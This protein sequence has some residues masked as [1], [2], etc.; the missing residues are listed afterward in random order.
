RKKSEDV[1]LP[2]GNQGAL[3]AFEAV[4]LRAVDVRIYR[5]YENNIIQF[6]QVN[7]LTGD[8]QLN[9]VGKPIF[10]KT[11][12]L[13]QYANTDLGQWNT[14]YIDLSKI[15][16]QQPG[17]LYHIKI[18]FRQENAITQC[19]D[20]AGSNKAVIAPNDF[21][22]MFTNYYYSYDY[23]WRDRDNPC[24]EAYYGYRRAMSHNFMV[25]DIGIIA[26]QGQGKEL[27]V[28]TT[29][30]SNTS[31]LPGTTVEVLDYQ[32]QVLA[33]QKTD[34]D[35]K[36]V[37]T[38][39]DKPY[40][41]KASDGNHTSYLRLTSSESLSYSHF[42]TDGVT[43]Q[44]GIKGFIY[45]ERGVY[46][47]GDTI[48]TGFMLNDI[49]GD[50]PENAPVT[51]EL[52]NARG[53]QIGKHVIPRN[54]ADHYLVHFNTQDDDETGLWNIKAM[55]GNITF[56]QSVS[57]ETVKPNRLKIDIDID[58]TVYAGEDQKIN[59]HS[60]WLHG[61]PVS[62]LKYTVEGAAQ[63]SYLKFDKYPGFEFNHKENQLRT[64]PSLY[65]SGSLDASGNAQIPPYSPQSS[66]LPSKV[67]L[68]YFFKV[69]EPNGNFSISSARQSYLPYETYVGLRLPEPNGRYNMF[70]TDKPINIEVVAVNAKGEQ[71][72]NTVRAKVRIYKVSWSWWWE[73]SSDFG[74][75]YK[76][77]KKLK[78]T[79][80]VNISGG[81][82]T[83]EMEMGRD[84]WGRYLIEVTNLQNNQVAS[85]F[86][87]FD[88]PSIAGRNN[89][90]DG[91]SQNM[92]RFATDK[93]EYVTGETVNLSFPTTHGG[94]A[95]ISIEDGV[96]VI[97]TYWVDT[98]EKETSFS[99]KTTP[100][101]S[102]N[103]YINIHYLQP[104]QNTGNDLPLRL[105][106]VAGIDVNNPDTKL[107]PIIEMD[108]SVETGKEFEITISEQE[109]KPMS[110]TI[111]IVD[112]GLLALT[113][114]RTPDPHKHFFSHEALGVI[115][116]DLFDWVIGAFNGTIERVIGIGGGADMDN[117][118]E[119]NADQRFKPVVVVE[120]PFDLRGGKS[121]THKIKLPPYI[122]E[123][124]TMVIARNDEAFGKAERST[125]VKSPL[126][127][128]ATA[129]RKLV[130]NDKFIVPV[131]I[132]RDQSS[133]GSVSVE[134][135]FDN[136]IK[137]ENPTRKIS[138][139]AGQEEQMIFFECTAGKN[140]GHTNFSVHA[141]DGSY[142]AKEALF[143][144][145][146]N[147]TPTIYNVDYVQLKD[148]E[149][150]SIEVNPIGTPST[151]K[152][153]AEIATMP[154]FN[155]HKH[156]SYLLNYPHGCI[157]QTVS[158]VLGLINA[159]KI[160]QIGENDKKRMDEKIDF[161]LKKLK[162]FQH[163]S[164]GFGYW[165]GS[166]N[167]N[168]WGTNYGGHFM[169]VAEKA[170]YK[171][172]QAV[173]NKWL[174][175]QKTMAK[176]W[177]DNGT[178]SRFN[179]A[180]R[181]YT[182][183]LAGKSQKGAMNR[184]RGIT[185]LHSATKWRLAAA[186]A[187]DG[188]KKAAEKLINSLSATKELATVQ[189]TYGSPLRDQA[190]VLQTLDYLDKN[191]EAFNLITEMSEKM[192]DNTWYSTQTRAWVLYAIADYY[193]KRDVAREINVSYHINNGKDNEVSTNMHMIQV[194]LPLEFS[195]SQNIEFTNKSGG[196][197]FL[198]LINEGK[199]LPK[200]LEGASSNLNI[201][202]TYMDFD[203]NTIN[204]SNLD[205]TTD[206][207]AKITV[208]HPGIRNSYTDLA[209]TFT[210]PGGWEIVN[211]RFTEFGGSINESTY[212]FRDFRDTQVMTYFYLRK[213]ETKTF[214]IKLNATYPG[215]YYFSPVIVEA[216][217]DH[218]INARTKSQFVDI[219][220]KE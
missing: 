61:A 89:R 208:S 7:D 123:V 103:C 11:V 93:E 32:Q 149:K 107:K 73:S 62:G 16:E 24:K 108:E 23:N 176:N 140:T 136:N 185:D 42:P 98:Q 138:F 121:M 41:I 116:Y 64:S 110:Y 158:G 119:K 206:F 141:M 9:R 1:I 137:V 195:L 152:L 164:G 163:S 182:L 211:T 142:T 44:N 132:F 3:F 204:I 50:L 194:D 14:F 94:K 184:L 126:M 155:A 219:K 35:G 187:V 68:S 217:Y 207:I 105:Y 177:V 145:I 46:R 130:M 49:T 71:Y 135:K 37:F 21:W 43:V 12:V 175:Y 174:R 65:H 10:E 153:T 87:Y 56:N 26:K 198:Q 156:F 95:L 114:F 54:K 20:G 172:D 55:I 144:E 100:E 167:V 67:N 53:Q 104:Y 151:N 133:S 81:A 159:A 191:T 101:M 146:Y 13:D 193:S 201:N 28:F 210:A 171:I 48:Y 77:Y 218:M 147:P 143:I 125:K 52:Y 139:G 83:F 92:L 170:G 203:R 148:N 5:V 102:P 202:V 168:E 186:Y 213:G 78:E 70:Q 162:K 118:P 173:Y 99:F 47:P 19:D 205:Q 22:D 124:R 112:E 189:Y 17:A 106:G 15:V 59:M 8:Y 197:T 57:V 154:P 169:I 216:M 69:F 66:S 180:Y 29:K 113:N 165:P 183:A 76:R 117:D 79:K 181:L 25:S 39:L 91:V 115:T 82:G 161:A 45:N 2:P 97:E 4:N 86:I 80:Y 34:S 122:G 190:M 63:K 109:G 160:M 51:I 74:Y 36:V 129:P 85:N 60:E 38:G 128:M 215:T 33:S 30:L 120:G 131:N 27:I 134:F 209:L 220:K 214:Y 212:T 127:V 88:W 178:T 179:Q 196:E 6:L 75:Y 84:D 96:K 72:N 58:E 157:E 31:I 192:I 166:S 199:P 111:A 90:P 188:R 40:F 18:A 200:E 150:R